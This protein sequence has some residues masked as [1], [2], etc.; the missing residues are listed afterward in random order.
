MGVPPSRSVVFEDAEAVI[1]TVIAGGFLC[2]GIG[3]E[4]RAGKATIRFS[5]ITDIQIEQVLTLKH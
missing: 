4:E 1:I 2:V 5:N 3:L